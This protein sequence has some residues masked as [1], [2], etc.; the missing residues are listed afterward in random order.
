MTRAGN[1][2]RASQKDGWELS[3]VPIWETLGPKYKETIHVRTEV[4]GGD[5]LASEGETMA[6]GPGQSQSSSKLTQCCA[7]SYLAR[8]FRPPIRLV[9]SHGHRDQEPETQP[10]WPSPLNI[11]SSG[12]HLTGLDPKSK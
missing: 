1:R 4:Q 6:Q 11:G 12:Y 7:S 10:P 5:L 2:T 3:E 8:A 9:Q